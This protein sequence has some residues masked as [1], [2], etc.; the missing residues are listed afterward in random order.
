MNS[1]V[2]RREFLKCERRR[3]PD[4]GGPSPSHDPW[5]SEQNEQLILSEERTDYVRFEQTSIIEHFED[6]T[7]EFKR[8]AL[9]KDMSAE[10]NYKTGQRGQG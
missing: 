9:D 2:G 6:R 1:D 10:L 7:F 4:E 8:K 3:T 5:T